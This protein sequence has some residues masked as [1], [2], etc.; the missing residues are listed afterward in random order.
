MA[1]TVITNIDYLVTVD[2][3]RRII[4]DGALVIQGDRIT[5]VGKTAEIK[6]QASDDIIEGR[7]KLAL[8]GVFDTHVHNAQQLGRSCGDEAWSGPERLFRRLW[9]VEAHM[10]KGDALCAA[11]LAQ[12][13][14]IRAGTTC[15]ADPGSYFAA[16]TAQAAKESGMRGMIARTV[17]DMGTTVMGNLPKG[18]FEPTEDALARADEM[19][20]EFDG[21]L[22][23]RLKAWF[24]MRVPVACSD[25]LLR[26]LCKLA[27]KRGVGII[28][29]ACEN[30][31]EV[32]AS[33]LK[34]GMGDIARL[35]KLGLLAPNLLL[36]HMGWIDPKELHMLQKRDVKISLAPSASMHQAMGNISHGKAPEMLELGLALSLGSDSAMSS[37]YLDAIRQAFLIVGGLHE[38]RLDPKVLRPEVAVEMLTIGGARCMLWDKDL[39]SLEVGKKADIT[40]LDTMRP[41]WQPVHNPIANLIYCAH[42]GCADTV[43]V[44]GKVLMRGGKVLTLNE[45]DLYEEAADRAKSLIKRAGLEDTVASIW[46]MH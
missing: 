6:V 7:G 25:D 41:E 15:F 33:H 12:V 13:E 43:I 14:M 35:E 3:G 20:A 10:D 4:R 34:Y 38:A 9:V 40:L 31:D 42:G 22:D 1:R 21:S 16:E 8:P 2:P 28:G 24:S 17:F 26:R 32:I 30:R 45:H 46:P 5:A 39:G 19:V 11:R 44:D 18:F 37:N 36:L 27:E 29:H 23:G